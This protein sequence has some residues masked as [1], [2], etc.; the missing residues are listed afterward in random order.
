MSTSL[1]F[2]AIGASLRGTLS[3]WVPEDGDVVS[4]GDL[5]YYVEHGDQIQEVSSPAVRR[6]RATRT[7]G[8]TYSAGE[9]VG[10]ID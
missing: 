1:L 8:L 5:L 7:P 6:L 10:F 3:S 4:P 2:P 9:V